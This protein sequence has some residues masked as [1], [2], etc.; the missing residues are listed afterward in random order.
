MQDYKKGTVQPKAIRQPPYTVE[1][2]GYSRLDGETVPRRNVRTA[3]QLKTRPHEDIATVFD[4]LKHASARYGNAKAM[5]SRKLI[6]LHRETKKMKRMVDG[7]EQEFEKEWTYSELSPYR[8]TTFTEHYQRALSLG[9]GLRKLGLNP[10]DKVSIYASTRCVLIHL[11]RFLC[12]QFSHS[13][14]DK[15]CSSPFRVSILA[16]GCW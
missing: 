9:C 2:K 13:S 7:A 6:K 14:V 16:F 12:A 11:E 1:A 8:F 4:V 3:D 10:G 5:G 15:P